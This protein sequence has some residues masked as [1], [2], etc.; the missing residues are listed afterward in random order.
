MFTALEKS[1]ASWPLIP[2]DASRTVHFDRRCRSAALFHSE[3]QKPNF[4]VPAQPRIDGPNP[5]A[6]RRLTGLLSSRFL[7]SAVSARQRLELSSIIMY[8]IATIAAMEL[9]Q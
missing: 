9:G 7:A 6:G 3:T 1:P 2:L 8:P 4:D 5:S